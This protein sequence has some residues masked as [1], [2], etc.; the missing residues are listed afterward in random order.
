M[1]IM[2]MP[3]ALPSGLMVYKIGL[4]V[5]V[6]TQIAL[7]LMTGGPIYSFYALIYATYEFWVIVYTPYSFIAAS[8]PVWYLLQL[9]D[10]LNAWMLW[11]FVALSVMALGEYQKPVG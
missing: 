10:H 6:A 3:L 5:K 2:Y 9:K 11:A 7:A 4:P 8:F 1:N